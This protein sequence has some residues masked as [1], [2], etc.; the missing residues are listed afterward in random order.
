MKHKKILFFTLIFIAFILVV[1]ALY[2]FN[3]IPHKKYSNEDFKIQRYISQ[4]DKDSDGIDDQ[5][6]ILDGVRSYI[7][8]HP[9]YK[10]KYYETGYPDDGYGVCTDVVAFGLQ[11]AG[12]HLM[13]LVNEDI[14]NHRETYNIETVNKNIDFRRVQNLKVYFANNSISLT[15]DIS[16]IE[17]WQGGD[18]VVFQK[19]IGIVSDKRNK[20]GLS[21]V[22]HHA[23]PYQR[24][25]EEDILENRN[26]IIGHYRI[27]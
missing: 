25:Y 24:H 11:N 17:Q 15:T 6:D 26:D 10:S 1:Y 18:I 21:F 16:D 2:H 13:E 12:Y 9:K 4:T 5:T 22:I 27:S 7:A 19:H 3:I 20:K 14:L 23:Y 8:T